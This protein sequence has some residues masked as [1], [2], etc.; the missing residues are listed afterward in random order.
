M[1]DSVDSKITFSI[2]YPTDISLNLKT[3]VEK[4][5]E[6]TLL[7]HKIIHMTIT[8][9]EAEISMGIIFMCK[10]MF[11]HLFT[12]FDHISKL[13]QKEISIKTEKSKENLA[14]LNKERLLTS[15]YEI[16]IEFNEIYL[17]ILKENK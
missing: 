5:N 11:D 17:S 15:K 9:I 4:E 3:E 1:L 13:L 16:D 6:D 10:N 2:I 7:C 12:K 8:P 14:F